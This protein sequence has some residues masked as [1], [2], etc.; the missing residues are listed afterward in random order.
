MSYLAWQLVRKDYFK[1]LKH[2]Q[3]NTTM[4]GIFGGLTICLRFSLFLHELS[5]MIYISAIDSIS[6][7]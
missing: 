7:W 2:Y 1:K 5:I 6:F 4:Y 3:N